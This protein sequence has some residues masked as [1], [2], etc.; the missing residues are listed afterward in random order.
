M[1]REIIAL[2]A[3]GQEAVLSS[4]KNIAKPAVLYGGNTESSTLP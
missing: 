2:L 3:G 1:A 4:Y